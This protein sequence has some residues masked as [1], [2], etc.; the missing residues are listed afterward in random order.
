MHIAIAIFWIACTFAVTIIIVVIL[1]VQG[2]AAGCVDYGGGS[3]RLC[4]FI[5][6]RHSGAFGQGWSCSGM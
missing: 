2:I 4:V 1:Y 5:E 6:A 3:S